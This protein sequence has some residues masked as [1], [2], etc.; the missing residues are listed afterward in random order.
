MKPAAGPLSHHL[1]NIFNQCVDTREFP[2]DA[3]LA[4]VVPLYKNDDNLN[5]KNYRPVSILPSMSKVLEK[6]ILHQMSRFLREIL[7]PRIAAYR[8]GYSCQDV[9]LK[10]I[11]D[12]KRALEKRRQVGAVLVDL[13]KAFDCLPHQ[14]VVAKLKAYGVCGK[15]CALIWSYLSGR[16]SVCASEARP[17]S[18][19]SSKREFRR[20][21]I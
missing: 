12:W 20:G 3:K 14:L 15:S 10:L 13:S 1:A 2:D 16:S 8:H 7:D 18:G 5:M 19:Y 4:E 6:I 9:L 11:D 21:R 17:V